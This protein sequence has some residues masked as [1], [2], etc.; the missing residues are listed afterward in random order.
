M[1]NVPVV[2]YPFLFGGAYIIIKY[3]FFLFS[4]LIMVGALYFY[5]FERDTND[6]K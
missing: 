3:A 5:L 4:F 2:L 1:R 6:R